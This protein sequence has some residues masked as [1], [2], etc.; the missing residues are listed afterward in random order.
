MRVLLAGATGAIGRPLVGQLRAAGHTVVGLTRSD[1]RA[2]ELAATGA[3][4]VV[5]D[6]LDRERL[7]ALAAEVE[8]EAVIHQL[9][10]LPRRID[11]RKAGPALAATNRLRVE[12]T[13]NLADAAAAAGARKLVA[14]SVAFAYDVGD[15]RLRSEDAPLV[16]R[17]PGA[18]RAVVDALRALEQTT[19]EAPGLGGVVLRYGYFYGPGTFY[20]RD[21]SIAEDVVRRRMPLVG[22]G[23][24]VFSFIHTD[25]AAAAT[26]AA[27]ERGKP[28]VYNVV[29]DEP[30][31][32]R[33]WLPVYAELL[34]APRPLKVPRL[35]ARLLAGPYAVYMM[36]L[37]PG[38]S[39]AK[40]K[41]ELGW[42]PKYP[43]W[44]DGFAAMLA[45]P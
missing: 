3:K 8:P 11:P 13:R 45:S 4:A 1:E 36:C 22:G 21:G 40:A 18:M 38:G 7:L 32:V 2:R 26:V 23:G 10:A 9:T 14:Q 5:C 16:R 39:N 43:S 33:D 34:R 20:A 42:S 6:A 44:R 17:P 35:L 12:G 30:A 19:L 25:D 15:G 31:A 24:G 28:G 41:A 27:L 29:D 37:Q